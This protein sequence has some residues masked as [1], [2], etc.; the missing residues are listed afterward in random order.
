MHSFVW[1]RDLV[2]SLKE[3]H[4][5]GEQSREDNIWTLEGK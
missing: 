4:R 2:L 5:F 3:E 1:V